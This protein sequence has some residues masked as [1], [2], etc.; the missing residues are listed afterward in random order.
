MRDL[1]ESTVDEAPC[2]EVLD[3]VRKSWAERNPGTTR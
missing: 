3:Q 2:F 1:Q